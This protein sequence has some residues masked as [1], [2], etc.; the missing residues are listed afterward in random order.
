MPTGKNEGKGGTLNLFEW[1]KYL[2]I[3]KEER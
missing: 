3:L 1:K 2:T